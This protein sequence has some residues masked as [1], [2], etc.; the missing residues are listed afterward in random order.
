[1][2]EKRI[3][4]RA[5]YFILPALYGLYAKISTMSMRFSLS[6][7]YKLHKHRMVKKKL[8]KGYKFVTT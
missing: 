5:L 2:P 6:N 4:N 3:H 8:Q 1:M 7:L